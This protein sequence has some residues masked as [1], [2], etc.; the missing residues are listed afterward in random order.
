MPE[1]TGR[2]AVSCLNCHCS[3]VKRLQAK[4]QS[5]QLLWASRIDSSKDR[6]LHLLWRDIRVHRSMQLGISSHIQSWV[7]V[8]SFEIAAPVLITKWPDYAIL[9]SRKFRS[10]KVPSRTLNYFHLESQKNH[11]KEQNTS[12]GPWNFRKG[13]TLAC[14]RAQHTLLLICPFS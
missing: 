14:S 8:C 5:Q 3:S 4:Y 13:N 9:K 7:S 1:Q 11:S 12:P 2:R 6:P 10:R